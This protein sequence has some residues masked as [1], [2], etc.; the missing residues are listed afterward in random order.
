MPQEVGMDA[1]RLQACHGGELAQDEKCARAC[2]RA[3]L[4]VEE[5]L[6]AVAAVEIRPSPGEIAAKGLHGLPADRDDSLLR[7]LAETA[8]E[9][10]FQVDGRAVEPDRLADAQ[11]GPVQELDER[12][13]AQGARRRSRRSLDQPLRLAR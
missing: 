13:V 1:I 12:P 2:Q 9:P 3:A 6:G 5:E 8:D 7:A 11:A 4:G 10:A